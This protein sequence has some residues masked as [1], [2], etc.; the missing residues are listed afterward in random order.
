MGEVRYNDEPAID[1]AGPS[2]EALARA[3]DLL[4]FSPN[5]PMRQRTPKGCRPHRIAIALQQL[6]DERDRQRLRAERAEQALQE[7]TC[8]TNSTLLATL[9]IAEGFKAEFGALVERL[10]AWTADERGYGQVD[11]ADEIDCILN[12]HLHTFAVGLGAHAEVK[13]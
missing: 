6:M 3:Y 5:D 7:F 12:D 13:P 2:K 10:R 8:S 4:G 9:A 11:Y 1:H